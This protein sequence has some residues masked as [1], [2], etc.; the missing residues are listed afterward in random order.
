MFKV[1]LCSRLTLFSLPFPLTNMVTLSEGRDAT[2]LE[3]VIILRRPVQR[4]PNMHQTH[5]GRIVKMSISSPY[6]KRFSF[7]GS[8]VGGTLNATKTNHRPL[9]Y[10]LC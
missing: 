3:G 10:I 1:L 8:W 4:F 7:T 5:P 9:T 2:Y 6:T